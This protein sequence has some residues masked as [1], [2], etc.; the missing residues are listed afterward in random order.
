MNQAAASLK[1]KPLNANFKLS[2]KLTQLE[3]NLA[4]QLSLHQHLKLV[5][6]REVELSASCELKELEHIQQRKIE[7][8]NKLYEIEDN[9]QPIVVEIAAA[10]GVPGDRPLKEMLPQFPQPAASRLA[11]LQAELKELISEIQLLGHSASQN[12]RSRLISLKATSDHLDK[13]MSHHT[14]YS[15][16]GSLQNTAHSR[17][18]SRHI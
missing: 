3:R 2:A 12:A 10:L 9:R 15:R 17:F 5:L 8:A 11:N 14:F 4:A 16:Q 6:A 18:L 1:E 13:W 7:I